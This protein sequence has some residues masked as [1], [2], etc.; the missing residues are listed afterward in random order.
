MRCDRKIVIIFQVM[1]VNGVVPNNM[2]LFFLLLRIA[3][4]VRLSDSPYSRLLL[5]LNALVTS[6]LKPYVSRYHELCYSSR[7]F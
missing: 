3:G 6:Q 2:V 4:G 1:K 5:E 7:T